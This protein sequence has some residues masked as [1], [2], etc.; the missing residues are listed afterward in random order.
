MPVYKTSQP[1]KDKRQ[2][3]FKISYT[4][5]LGTAR[6]YKSKLYKTKKEA[7]KAEAVFRLSNEQKP[8]VEYTFNLVAIP[9]LE[10][11][12]TRLKPQSYD[13]VEIMLK[14]M[15]ETLGDVPVSELTVNQYSTALKNLDEYT[16]HGRKLAPQYKNKV[17]ANFKQLIAFANKRYDV[18]TNIPTKFDAYKKEDSIEEM[19]F[20]TLEEFNQFIAVVDDPIYHALFTFLF[21]MGSRIGEANALT[22]NDVDFENNTVRINKTVSTKVKDKNG[23]YLVTSPKTKSSIRTLPLPQI[24]SKELLNLHEHQYKPAGY[25]AEM[26]VFGIYTPIPESTLQTVKNNYF[27]KAGLQPIRIHDF[28]HSCASFL[29]NNG[30]TVL[31]VSKWLGHANPTMTL[32]IYSHLWQSELAQI[33]DAI[34]MKTE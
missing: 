25:E 3:F 15:L 18:F 29:V 9:F 1:T 8:K 12:K 17:V 20:I 34:N 4:D 21:F 33:V 5:P 7:E 10:E 2:Y 31:L 24:V 27:K 28:R 19:R 14:H 22:W 13:R 6:Q 16:F 26:Y 32:K 23:N 30:A 11:K